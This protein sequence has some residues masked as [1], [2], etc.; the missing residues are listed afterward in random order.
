MAYSFV[1][2]DFSLGSLNTSKWTEWT[3]AAGFPSEHYVNTSEGRYHVVQD[4]QADSESRLTMTRL[5]NPGEVLAYD[6]YYNSGDGNR[7][8]RIFFDGV[9]IQDL[10]GCSNCGAVGFWNTNASAGTE[11]GKHTM[12]Y[13]FHNDAIEATVIRPDSSIWNQTINISSLSKPYE[14]WLATG[15]GHNGLMHFDIDNVTVTVAE[16]P[17]DNTVAYWRFNESSG[18]T[19]YDETGIH[20]G[21]ITGAGY[22]EGIEGTALYY[23]GSGDYVQVPDHD[24]LTLTGGNFTVEAYFKLAEPH[25][26]G[27]SPKWIVIKNGEYG[28]FLSDDGFLYFYIASGHGIPATYKTSNINEWEAGIWYHVACVYENASQW[29]IYVDHE[30][31]NSGNQSYYPMVTDIDLL[32]GTLHTQY[33]KGT[34]DEVRITNASLTPE[35]FLYFPWE[36]PEPPEPCNCSSLQEQIDSLEERVTSL[37]EQIGELGGEQNCSARLDDV[38]ERVSVLEAAFEGI[39]EAVEFLRDGMEGINELILSYLNKLPHGLSKRF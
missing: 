9:G 39:E 1:Y 8:H 30:L 19:A 12:S 36:P 14:I 20:N 24:G 4:T 3:D 15:T 35:E 22:V 11:F 37:E 5:M 32:I 16:E 31:A 26:Y 33:F 21:T 25:L 27:S 23:G 18:M 2:D 29:R 28:I 38:E 13:E 34:I 17:V 6:L 7:I 10:I